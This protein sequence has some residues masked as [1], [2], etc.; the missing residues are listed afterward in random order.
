[1]QLQLVVRAVD[2]LECHF[3][4]G[5][6]P[7]R[8][9]TWTQAQ[10]RGTGGRQPL[11]GPLAAPHLVLIPPVQVPVQHHTSS[12]PLPDLQ[13]HRGCSGR[14][15][16]LCPWHGPGVAAQGTGDRCG[17]GAQIAPTGALSDSP[18]RAM[19]MANS[20]VPSLSK[21]WVSCG[22]GQEGLEPAFSR[23]PSAGTGHPALQGLIWV[24]PSSEDRWGQPASLQASRTWGDP[25]GGK[26]WQRCRCPR[27]A[28]TCS[29]GR[30][31]GT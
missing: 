8:P 10:T 11:R 3:L 18:H 16:S 9:Q 7:D 1:M 6:A 19:K 31:E 4:L 26:P 25:Q 24:S 21:R 12:L 5:R 15:V 20:T 23:P 29:C 27:G 30:R 28:G 22:E 17:P 14:R 13:E 2:E